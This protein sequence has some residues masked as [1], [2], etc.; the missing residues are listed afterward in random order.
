MPVVRLP[1]VWAK[2]RKSLVSLL[3]VSDWQT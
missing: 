1:G 3:I 2:D